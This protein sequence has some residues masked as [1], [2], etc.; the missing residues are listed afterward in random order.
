[1]AAPTDARDHLPGSQAMTDHVSTVKG[2]FATLA[3]KDEFVWVLGGLVVAG[4][5]HL[6]DG[7]SAGAPG[8]D[9]ALLHG[10]GAGAV[11]G[12]EVAAEESGVASVW[13]SWP[14]CGGVG[15]WAGWRCCVWTCS[16]SY[17][18]VR[19][20]AAGGRDIIVVASRRCNSVSIQA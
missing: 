4:T 17:G 12:C 18:G 14:R 3:V 15:V 6:G 16:R 8:H 2:H 5:A 9:Y 11:A 13:R 7:G 19:V 20:G 1:M 10:D